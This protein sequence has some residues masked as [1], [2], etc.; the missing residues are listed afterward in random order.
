LAIL[1]LSRSDGLV[2][3]IS[4][5]KRS[6]PG[7][8]RKAMLEESVFLMLRGQTDS[9]LGQFVAMRVFFK[10]NNIIRLAAIIT[11]FTKT[12]IMIILFDRNENLHGVTGRVPIRL[13]SNTSQPPNGSATC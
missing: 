7:E 9:S 6:D 3:S 4:G 2:G 13:F 10:A 1:A 11:T 8:E 5:Y 12:K